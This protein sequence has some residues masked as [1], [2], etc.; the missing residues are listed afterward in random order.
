MYKSAFFPKA[1]VPAEV[2][3]LWKK[4]MMDKA[5]N[6]KLFTNWPHA[7][8]CGYQSHKTKKKIRLIRFLL[9]MADMEEEG[10]HEKD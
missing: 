10:L 9:N 3:D 4:N 5:N 6:P 1:K 2:L 7:W 8:I